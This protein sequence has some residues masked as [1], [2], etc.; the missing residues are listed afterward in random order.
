[1]IDLD[2]IDQA[3]RLFKPDIELEAIKPKPASRFFGSVAEIPGVGNVGLPRYTDG[4]YRH[5]N[6]R[7][8]KPPMRALYAAMIVGAVVI[9]ALGVPAMLWL[10]NRIRPQ[11]P[12]QNERDRLIYEARRRLDKFPY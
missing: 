1:M 12:E 3:L 9:V 10:L 11:T 7:R 2:A 6:P 5:A 4:V 8:R